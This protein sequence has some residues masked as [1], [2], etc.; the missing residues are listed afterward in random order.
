MTTR[1][2]KDTPG[3]RLLGGAW[4]FWRSAQLLYEFD[5][6][7]LAWA[8]MFVHMNLA[9][10]LALKGFLREKGYSEKQQVDLGH[11]LAKAFACARQEGFQPSHQAQEA[12]ILELN[13]HHQDMSLRYLQ[14][15][16]VNL[17]VVRDAL[18][19]VLSLVRDL[20]TQAK[21]PVPDNP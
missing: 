13:P 1:N 17:P 16:S 8:T 10:E 15:T 2:P 7:A 4:A 6:Q 14:G 18:A 11:N 21:I 3:R 19:I 20:H 12:L 9:I 5:P